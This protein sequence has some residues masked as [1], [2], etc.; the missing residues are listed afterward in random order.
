MQP[1]THDHVRRIARLCKLR[2][3]EDEAADAAVRLTAVLEHMERLGELDLKGVEPMA[4]ATDEPAR[5]RADEPGPTLG[6]EAVRSLAPAVFEPT[7]PTGE[8]DADGQPRTLTFIAVPS[9]LDRGG[10]A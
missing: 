8:V 7:D 3:S 9:V 6:V 1:L 2:L 10:G 4:R 5:L